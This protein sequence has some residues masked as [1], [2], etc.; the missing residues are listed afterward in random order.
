[1]GTAELGQD[2]ELLCWGDNL[3]GKVGDD[4]EPETLSH[5]EDRAHQSAVVVVGVVPRS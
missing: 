5:G 3:E 1:M 4:F 2:G